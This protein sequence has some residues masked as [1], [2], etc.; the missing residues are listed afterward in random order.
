MI[1]KIFGGLGNQMFQYAYG[2]SLELSGKKVVFDISFF[3]GNKARIDT[4]RNFKLDKFNITTKAKFSPQKHPIFDIWIKIKR[5]LGLNVDVYFQ[6]EKYFINIADNIRQEF[7]LKK[8]LSDKV[9]EI[10]NNITNNNSTS[11]HIRRGD[12]IDDKKTNAFHGTC[13]L[14]Y[15]KKAIGLIKEKIQIQ[16]FLFFLMILCGQKKILL[17][18]NLFLFQILK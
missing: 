8:S 3:Q 17:V 16:C 4:A 12:Y 7:T 15:Y 9:R 5:R 13:D 6:N 1:V 10:V 11:L 18:M 2:R 14:D